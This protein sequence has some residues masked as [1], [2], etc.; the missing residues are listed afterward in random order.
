MRCSNLVFSLVPRSSLTHSLVSYCFKF[1]SLSLSLSTLMISFPYQEPIADSRICRFQT[2]R[3]PAIA[4]TPRRPAL[5]GGAAEA[6]PTNEHER[7][8]LGGGG[9]GRLRLRASAADGGSA[10]PPRLVRSLK[11]NYATQGSGQVNGRRMRR[12]QNL[13]CLYVWSGRAMK[14]TKCTCIY[15]MKLYQKSC[16]PPVML[17]IRVK[18]KL[19]NCSTL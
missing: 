4:L 2:G 15:K 8:P 14:C 9:A 13:N 6:R 11:L 17:Q 3:C 18:G 5:L 10:P 12:R 1:Y 19:W 7:S 16:L